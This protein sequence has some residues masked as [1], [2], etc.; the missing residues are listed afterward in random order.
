MVHVNYN[1]IYPVDLSHCMCYKEA[2]F[3]N[4]ELRKRIAYDKFIFLR[5]PKI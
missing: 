5:L 3:K 4:V 1:T 2:V